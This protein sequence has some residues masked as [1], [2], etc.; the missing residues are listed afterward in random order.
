MNSPAGLWKQLGERL[1]LFTVWA[2]SSLIDC[3]F[4]L[5]WVIA[6]WL[7]ERMEPLV[8]S[9]IH[10]YEF[11]LFV[12]VF[13]LST[14]APVLSYLYVDIRII[15]LQARQTVQVAQHPKEIDEHVA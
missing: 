3:V 1:T 14:I 4:L 13:A 10:R 9:P 8:S 11:Q 12:V 2:V 5:I 15:V 7:V 6:Q